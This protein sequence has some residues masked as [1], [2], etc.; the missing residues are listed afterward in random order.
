MFIFCSDAI[1]KIILKKEVKIYIAKMDTAYL[2]SPRQELV[3]Y[4]L[5]FV[6]ALLFFSGIDFSCAC[7]GGLTQLDSTNTHFEPFFYL[8]TVID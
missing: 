5:S 6:V 1:W 7:T 3:N 2:D 8:L 4:V